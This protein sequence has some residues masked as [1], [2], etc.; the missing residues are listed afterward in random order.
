[1]TARRLVRVVV[2]VLVLLSARPA[3]AETV[4]MGDL[5]SISNAGLYIAIEKGFFGEKGIT[6]ETERFSSAAKMMAPLATGELDVAIS[7]PSAGLY[8]A[9]ASGMDFKIVAHKGQQRPG[10][11][12]EP[13][14]VRKDHVDSGRVKTVKD[15]KGLKVAGS[16]KGIV[17]D[18]FMAKF[19]EHAGLSFDVVDMTYMSFPDGIKALQAKAIDAM[20]G[21]EPWG[22]RA[23]QL[24]VGV[25]KFLSEDVPSIS[26]FQVGVVISSGKFLRERRKVAKDFLAGYLRG[27][28]YYNEKGLKDPEV[29]GLIAK[30]VG[31][32]ADTVRATIPVYLEPTG[33]PRLDDI[34]RLQDWLQAIGWVKMKA[35]ME[36]L[37]DLSLLE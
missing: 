13:L 25:R 15:L 3:A 5:P 29:A 4:K 1:M 27:I 9:A 26:T 22:V 10:Y 32:P 21:P 2:A 24:G 6:V 19:L 28:A 34:A 14:I 35:P 11:S 16:A 12:Y 31:V 30:H 8:N 23:E 18:Y 17:L 20:I 36:R 37:V 7:S 33:K